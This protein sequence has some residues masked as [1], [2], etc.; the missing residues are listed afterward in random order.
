M[1]AAAGNRGVEAFACLMD[2]GSAALQPA[3]RIGHN[4]ASYGSEAVELRLRGACSAPRAAANGDGPR[5]AC[6]TTSVFLP[7]SAWWLSRPQ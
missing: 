1:E 7:S 4:P 6:P 2:P 3:A 5:Q